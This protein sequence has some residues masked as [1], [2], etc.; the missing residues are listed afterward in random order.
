[1]LLLLLKPCALPTL[2]VKQV[3]LNI[4]SWLSVDPRQVRGLAKTSYAVL[5]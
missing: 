3:A 5:V 2:V 4:Q 1:M